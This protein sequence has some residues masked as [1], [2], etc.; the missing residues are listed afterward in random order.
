[1]KIYHN[2][3]CRKSREGLAFLEQNRYDFE[4]V[5]YLE[6]PLTRQELLSIIE[7]LEVSPIDLIRRSESVW[8][9]NFKGKTLSDQELVEAMLQFPKLMERP[10]VVH[11]E[12]AII[13]RP[14][15]RI[16]DIL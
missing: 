9:E 5:R 4:V 7:K 10:I 16:K 8:K 13:A 15:E 3:R 1:M 12:R 6:N 14:A 11:N 2:P